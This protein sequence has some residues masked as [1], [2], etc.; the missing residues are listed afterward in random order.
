MK[1][2]FSGLYFATH[3]FNSSADVEAIK[4]FVLQIV[5]TLLGNKNSVGGTL[6]QLSQRSNVFCALAM[7]PKLLLEGD[8]S[9]AVDDVV[10]SLFL[11]LDKEIEPGNKLMIG[12]VMG[13]MY[14]LQYIHI[15]Y[16]LYV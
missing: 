5:D 1:I 15:C 8:V 9:S 2:C 16:Q 4:L 3:L 12:K 11:L 14:T 13:T 10:T 6:T 7:T